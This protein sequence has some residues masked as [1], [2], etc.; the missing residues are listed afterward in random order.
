[1]AQGRTLRMGNN[2]AFYFA[3]VEPEFFSNTPHGSVPAIVRSLNRTNRFATKMPS[4]QR[5]NPPMNLARAFVTV[6]GLT[7]ISACWVSCATCCLPPRGAGIGADAF[8]VAFKLPNFFRRLFAEGA[9]NAA[10]IPL[11]A[12]R[13]ERGKGKPNPWP[14]KPR[15][16]VAGVG[17]AHGCIRDRDALVMLGLAPASSMSP[18][19]SSSRSNSAPSPFPI[20]C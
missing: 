14:M 9:F 4:F 8:L 20:C 11:F 13:L 12:G 18:K 10:F 15:R 17:R 1:M 19:S 16:P 2:H 6:S 7:A 3:W 5:R